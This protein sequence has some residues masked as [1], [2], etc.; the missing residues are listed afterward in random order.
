MPRSGEAPLPVEV[1]QSSM[2]TL[3]ESLVKIGAKIVCHSRSITFQMAEVM[4][5]RGLFEKSCLP[6]RRSVRCRRHDAEHR[7]NGCHIKLS[8]NRCAR[9][10]V[11][12]A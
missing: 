12:R 7:H 1:E 8:E 3:R 10:R 9:R 11:F 6:L 2:T 5:P 4:V